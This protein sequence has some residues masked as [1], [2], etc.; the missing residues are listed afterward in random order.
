MGNVDESIKKKML[1]PIGKRV[2]FQYPGDEGHKTGVLK[3]RVIMPSNPGETG[4]PYWD[5]VDLIEFSEEA[6][7]LWMRIGYYRK[8]G[9]HLVW[10]SQTTI[11]EPIKV[12]KRLLVQAASQKP[13]F[14]QLLIEVMR[15]LQGGS[16]TDL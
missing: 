4:V 10:G 14:K 3:D 2:H 9:E 13:W 11:T 5:V 1:K 6:E 16:E 15:E 7:P 12:W 8:P